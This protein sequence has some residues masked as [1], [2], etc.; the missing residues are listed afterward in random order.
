MALSPELLAAYNKTDYAVFGAPELVLHVGEASPELD[1]L[2]ASEGAATAAYVT[3]ANP[4]GRVLS[5]IE[6]HVACAA[7]CDAQI[8][9]GY[10]CYPGEGRD[11]QGKWTAEPSVLVVG[12]ARGDAL[13]LGR[14]LEQ[15]AIV[16]VERGLPPELL[17]LED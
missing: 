14:A 11:P 10:A 7:L 13:A 1:A 5:E 2:L 12:I 6:N 15:N 3:A 16:F 8:R 4:R 9:A 17:V